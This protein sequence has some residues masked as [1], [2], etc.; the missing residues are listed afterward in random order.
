MQVSDGEET[1]LDL[2]RLQATETASDVDVYND[3]SEQQKM[4]VK[5]ILSEYDDVLTDLPGCTKLEEH[6]VRMTSHTPIRKKPY[7][8]PFH[9]KEAMRLE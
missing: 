3:L 1:T 9:A 2:L 7:P 4:E 5:Q 8:I 6:T